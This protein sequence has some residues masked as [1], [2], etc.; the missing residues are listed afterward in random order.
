MA[1]SRTEICNMA[2]SHVGNSHPID[3]IDEGSQQANTCK[4]FYFNV[5]DALLRKFDFPFA[6]RTEPLELISE[7]EDY[8]DDYSWRFIYRQ[9]QDC[10]KINHLVDSMRPDLRRGQIKYQRGRN[11]T[12]NVIYTNQENAVLEYISRPNESFFDPDFV[13]LFSLGLAV[14]IA[15]PLGSDSRILSNVQQL[16]QGT[17]RDVELAAAQESVAP[18]QPES[19]FIAVRDVDYYENIKGRLE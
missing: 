14:R 8:V 9:P 1:D 18:E 5:L 15:M 11:D 4:L 12:T 2:L 19:E 17:L 3:H 10:V 6:R 7:N 16:Y 13:M